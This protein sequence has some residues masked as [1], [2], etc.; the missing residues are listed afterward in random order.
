MTHIHMGS[1][2]GGKVGGGE[3]VHMPLALALG[4]SRGRGGTSLSM[5][6]M[7]PNL[8]RRRQRVS[9]DDTVRAPSGC[10]AAV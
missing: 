6:I 3:T 7:Y 10:E 1:E 9:D 5:I 4:G 8:N 2:L